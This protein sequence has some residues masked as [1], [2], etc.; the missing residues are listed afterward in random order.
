MIRIRGAIA[1]GLRHPLLG[2][3]LLLLIVVALALIAVHETADDWLLPLLAACVAAAFVAVLTGF[4]PP[5]RP[6]A[7]PRGRA[8]SPSAAADP[9]RPAP[10]L[11]ALRR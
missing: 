1:R 8:R 9:F 7:F 6:G 3:L 2:P 5:V 10:I 11:V 4:R